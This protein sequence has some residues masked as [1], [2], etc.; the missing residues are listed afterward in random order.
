MSFLPSFLPS[1]LH[2]LFTVHC[3]LF[4][5]P[6]SGVKATNESVSQGRCGVVWLCVR[7]SVCVCVCVCVCLL[8]WLVGWLV[9]VGVDWWHALTACLPFP[10]SGTSTLVIFSTASPPH[11]PLLV[12]PQCSLHPRQPHNP[13][14]SHLQ[15]VTRSPPCPHFQ[16]RCLRSTALPICPPVRA[17]SQLIR[18]GR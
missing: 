9:L 11:T 17:Y 16:S 13:A 7:A 12:S 15:A 10:A 6:A 3:S 2:S 5:V 8:G 14:L 4:T 18:S 1:F